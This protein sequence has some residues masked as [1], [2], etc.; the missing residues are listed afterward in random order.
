MTHWQ[1]TSNSTFAF[2]P[3]RDD[4]GNLRGFAK[5]LQDLTERKQAEEEREELLKRERAA[6]AE[7]ESANRTKDDFLAVVS[8]EL[9]TPTIAI[10]GWAGM[11]RAGML[12]EANTA[13]A[14][15]TI[16]R[17]ANSQMQLIEDLLDISRIVRGEIL[18]NFDRVI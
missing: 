15:E 16:D 12:D 11:L 7:A 6:R 9:R 3:L 17:N 10:V 13:S 18:L 4:R 14:I 1:I 5:I 8:H 2:T